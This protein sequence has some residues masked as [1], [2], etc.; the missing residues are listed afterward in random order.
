MY[1]R[2]DAAT[3]ADRAVK[4]YLYREDSNF[5][6]YW[7]RFPWLKGGGGICPIICHH[8]RLDS[9]SSC[10]LLSSK[11]HFC[12]MSVICSWLVPVLKTGTFF[13][14][15]CLLPP[16]PKLPRGALWPGPHSTA[17]ASP[18]QLLYFFI[19]CTSSTTFSSHLTHP[20]VLS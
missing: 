1:A 4:K 16:P 10:G 13:S 9:Q 19:L 8:R 11:L 6:N 12:F 18:P 3:G 5:R 17:P 14:L 7:T 2:D 20:V 15:S